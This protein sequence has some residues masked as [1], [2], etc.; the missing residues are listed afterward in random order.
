MRHGQG[1]GHRRD[2]K[3]LCHHGG[4]KRSAKKIKVWQESTV[5]AQSDPAI[6]R[7]WRLWI[8]V[9]KT[10]NC[11][12]WTITYELEQL[13]CPMIKRLNRQLIGNLK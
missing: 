10:I 5:S 12:T 9:H 4:L 2:E 8:I 1:N 3:G 11:P 13:P 7:Q 6:V